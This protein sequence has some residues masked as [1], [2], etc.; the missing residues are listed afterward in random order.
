M[1]FP[2]V[3]AIYTMIR[4]PFV[5]DPTQATLNPD[6]T[7]GWWPYPFL[8]PNLAPE[9]YVSVAFYV[10]L[11]AGVI[12]GV[13]A[14]VIWASRRGDAG[15]CRHRRPD[16]GCSTGSLAGAG[17]LCV[18]AT[19]TIIWIARIGVTRDLYVSELGAD[20]EPTAAWFERA[21]LLLVAGGFAIAWA[22]RRIRTRLPVLRWWA[23]SISL[24][25][26]SAPVPRR[27]AGDL[28]EWMPGAAV[29][30]R[31]VVARP[32][33]RHRRDR[34]PSRSR[35]GRCCSARSRSGTAPSAASRWSRRSRSRSSPA[36]GG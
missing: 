34:S 33:A 8:N 6:Y 9:G 15:R 14:L 20:G 17:T 7:V 3:W 30:P 12:G 35:P 18:L 16:P 23:P 13:G 11:I 19:L 27:V 24:A 2:I 22:G 36:S 1:I 21:L 32:R 10:V 4:G 31:P 25:V 29:R 28:H 26:A 5:D